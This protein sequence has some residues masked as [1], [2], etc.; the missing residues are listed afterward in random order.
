MATLQE[1]ANSVQQLAADLST[2]V[3]NGIPP[4]QD[5]VTEVRTGLQQVKDVVQGQDVKGFVEEQKVSTAVT[6]N[7]E[8]Y[9]RGAYL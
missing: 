1:V 5:G 7:S 3:N 4:I 6:A 2:L 9:L 8:H